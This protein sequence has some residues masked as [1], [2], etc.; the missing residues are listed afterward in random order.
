MTWH[1]Q[2]FENLEQSDV[3][4]FYDY[5]VDPNTEDTASPWQG[6]PVEVKS[7]PTIPSGLNGAPTGL[8]VRAGSG[9]LRVRSD[10]Y[11]PW[12]KQGGYLGV[13]LR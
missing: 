12:L 11:A 6:G 8:M 13:R 3:V 1:L 7:A 2:S 4:E 5:G 10:D 9:G